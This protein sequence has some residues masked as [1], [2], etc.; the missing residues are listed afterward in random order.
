ML[1]SAKLQTSPSLPDSSLLR[2]SRKTER[3][4]ERFLAHFVVRAAPFA[5]LKEAVALLWQ[6]KRDVLA[7]S[8]LQ[9]QCR[10]EG[11]HFLALLSGRIA[12]DSS[13]GLRA[14]LLQVLESDGCQSLTVDLHEVSYVDTSGL[15]ILMEVLQGARASGKAFQLRNLQQRPRYLFQAIG[16]LHFFDKEPPEGGEPTGAS[17]PNAP[18]GPN[19]Q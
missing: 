12:I 11:T 6:R 17:G 3:G 13:P 7:D 2:N 19:Q 18:S 10:A 1:V 15:A 5:L 16:L 8:G 9:L 14:E 4:A